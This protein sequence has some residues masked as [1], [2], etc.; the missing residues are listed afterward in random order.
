M[1][2]DLRLSLK[3]KWFEMTKAGVKTEDYR[4]PNPYWCNR[5]ILVNGKIMPKKWWADK[6]HKIIWVGNTPLKWIID[7]IDIGNFTFKPFTTTTLTLGY[8]ANHELHRIIRFEHLGIEIR[9]GNP[10]FGAEPNKLYF[11]IKHGQP[12]PSKSV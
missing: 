6:F 12:L 1:K 2:A 7:S 5:L 9:T 8:P 4:L 3:S 10:E 11:V